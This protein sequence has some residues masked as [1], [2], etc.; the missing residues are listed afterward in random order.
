M[1]RKLI[2]CVLEHG[3]TAGI[4]VE[5]EAYTG[6]NDPGS[7][8]YRGRRTRNAPMFG[9]PG[10][11]YVYQCHIWPLL[12]VV[13]EK[14]GTPWAVLIRAL[15]PVRGLEIMRK[16]RKAEKDTDLTRGPGRLTQALGITLR[17]NR[18][19]LRGPGLR[20]TRGPK[21]FRCRIAR[22][23]RIGLH[24]PAARLPWRYHAAGCPFVS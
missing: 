15:I 11:A 5:T 8:A 14:E 9:P 21:G 4:I 6:E 16:R 13:T 10:R 22:T 17:D 24:G 12:N 7:H 19:D 20:I 2:G 3:R 1:A 18:A 23:A